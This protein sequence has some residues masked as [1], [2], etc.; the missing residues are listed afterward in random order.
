MRKM[1]YLRAAEHEE[2]YCGTYFV[3]IV[4]DSTMSW[5]WPAEGRAW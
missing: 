4:Q 2:M 5:A 3:D 1:R